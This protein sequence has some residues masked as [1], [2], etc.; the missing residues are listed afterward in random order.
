MWFH[1]ILVHWRSLMVSQH[2]PWT[3]AAAAP[4]YEAYATTGHALIHG[5]SGARYAHLRRRRRSLQ[6]R[7]ILK[8]WLSR[9]IFCKRDNRY[10]APTARSLPLKFKVLL[11]HLG[12]NCWRHSAFPISIASLTRPIARRLSSKAHTTYARLIALWVC[13]RLPLSSTIIRV[14]KRR[15]LSLNPF[16]RHIARISDDYLLR[17]SGLTDDSDRIIAEFI[18]LA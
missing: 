12:V 6:L 8:S 13:R 2:A 5:S 15:S 4:T 9:S 7:S 3:L 1:R 14:V 10:F 11:R 16:D 17:L 18:N